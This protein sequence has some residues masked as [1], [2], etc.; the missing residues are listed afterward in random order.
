M[1]VIGNDTRRISAKLTTDVER[2]REREQFLLADLKFENASA[3]VTAIGPQSS[4]HFKPALSTN[5]LARI[6]SGEGTHT[7]GTIVEIWTL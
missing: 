1:G 4:A 2:D 7:S 5:C 3:L 6:P